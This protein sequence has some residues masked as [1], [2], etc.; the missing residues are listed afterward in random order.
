MSEKQDRKRIRKRAMTIMSKIIELQD[1]ER[2][3]STGL[4]PCSTEGFVQD[5]TSI[6]YEE[7]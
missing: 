6:V 2:Q 1:L 3:L 4:L 5:L 7:D